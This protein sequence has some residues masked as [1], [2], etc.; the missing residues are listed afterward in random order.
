M[1][2][3]SLDSPINPFGASYLNRAKA[4]TYE[5]SDPDFATATKETQELW[6]KQIE[7]IT[8]Q[9]L[10]L[11]ALAEQTRG[12]DEE[13]YN[14]ILLQQEA[15]NNATDKFLAEGWAAYSRPQWD[16]YSQQYVQTV[17]PV[18]N[19]LANYKEFIKGVNERQKTDYTYV[20]V[21]YEISKGTSGYLKQFNNPASH[22][23][24]SVAKLRKEGQDI[25]ASI[26]D[27][28][29]TKSNFNLS[30]DILNKGVVIEELN[31]L[32][33]ALSSTTDIEA[34]INSLYNDGK[35]FTGNNTFRGVLR[36]QLYQNLKNKSEEL[37]YFSN[38]AQKNELLRIYAQEIINGM[39]VEGQL[40]TSD[41]AASLK[42]AGAKQSGSGY[43]ATIPTVLTRSTSINSD[44]LNQTDL[45]NFV[46][47]NPNQN[48]QNTE[49]FLVNNYLTE[50]GIFADYREALQNMDNSLKNTNAFPISDINTL[51]VQNIEYHP[52]TATEMYDKGNNKE[53]AVVITNTFA[54]NAGVIPNL[55]EDTSGFK[56][57]SM[58]ETTWYKIFKDR[59]YSRDAIKS[60]LIEA[61]PIYRNDPDMLVLNMSLGMDA[62][63]ALPFEIQKKYF[64]G[65]F[66]ETL[67]NPY[68][69]KGSWSENEKQEFNK[70]ALNRRQ[71]ITN[72][73]QLGNARRKLQDEYFKHMRKDKENQSSATEEERKNT[74]VGL[75]M[76]DLT[77]KLVNNEVDIK[78]KEGTLNKLEETYKSVTDIVLRKKE[79]KPEV[80]HIV[81]N[82]HAQ[83]NLDEAICDKLH[84]M[85]GGRNESLEGVYTWNSNKGR[86]DIAENVSIVTNKE[87]KFEI[88]VGDIRYQIGNFGIS[89]DTIKDGTMT[90]EALINNER[91]YFSIPDAD[92]ANILGT[93]LQGQR[94]YK[95]EQYFK[96][97]ATHFSNI[98]LPT[99]AAMENLDI[100][101]RNRALQ[102]FE[103]NAAQITSML[104]NKEN[105]TK[106]LNVSAST[107]RRLFKEF[108][109]V[110]NSLGWTVDT[111]DSLTHNKSKGIISNL[112]ENFSKTN[113]PLRK[114]D[115]SNQ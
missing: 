19:N 39:K 61:A 27:N 87:G 93:D 10:E 28:V 107:E 11:S 41:Y 82:D 44:Y 24:L 101:T 1:S 104:Y 12:V 32:E 38:P 18:A 43:D 53:K 55:Y 60:K 114:S 110:L 34:F 23:G 3:K 103:Q 17:T 26:S 65:M 102:F 84:S 95:E 94:I 70:A 52:D 33:R 58:E 16:A 35:D 7:N 90:V 46:G 78:D 108:L 76:L 89:T 72:I 37:N 6:D 64:D 8:K 47:K 83:K 13:A 40:A 106:P 112:L 63:A 99:I 100:E 45:P 80:I 91:Y 67:K 66:S 14:N 75:S 42:G 74:V 88:K 56:F 25:G 68:P 69:N 30:Y 20:P 81:N 48:I 49:S 29:L 15:L 21:E 22:K 113:M 57:P 86:F 79:N 97:M 109:E 62:I 31:D 73:L 54:G 51:G 98:V 111:L 2:E 5:V 50:N 36:N 59:G 71:L 105:P 77:L 96:N 9:Q 92:M 85:S 115:L 4:L